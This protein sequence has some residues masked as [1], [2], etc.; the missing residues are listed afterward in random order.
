M[1]LYCFFRP[2]KKFPD[3][4]GDLSAI[5][6]PAAIRE[7]NKEVAKVME[8]AECRKRKSYKKISDSLR[9]QIGRYALENGNAAA[10][11]HFSKEF[12]TSLSEST[13]RSLKKSY[14]S[15]RDALKRKPCQVKIQHWKVCHQRNV[16]DHCFLD[17]QVQAY[18]KNS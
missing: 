3:P 13:V 14:I 7:V 16:V 12:E 17:K 9:A 6:L 8:A 2:V 18:V 10:V 5:V 4:N 1:S 15:A 11:R